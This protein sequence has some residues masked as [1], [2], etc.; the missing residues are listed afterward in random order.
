VIDDVSARRGKYGCSFDGGA[1]EESDGEARP[2]SPFSAVRNEPGGD[3]RGSVRAGVVENDLPGRVRRS[4]E[5]PV[6][7]RS[8]V[9]GKH[10]ADSSGDGAAVEVLGDA[11]NC[12]VVSMYETNR[13]V[14]PSVVTVTGSIGLS[15]LGAATAPVDPNRR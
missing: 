9:E 8:G 6:D 13:T 10:G 15:A 4:V 7:T 14:R 12:S 11:A 5:H 1:V 2:P 3:R